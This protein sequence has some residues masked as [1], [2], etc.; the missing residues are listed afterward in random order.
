MPAPPPSSRTSKPIPEDAPLDTSTLVS[1]RRLRVSEQ[2]SRLL[3]TGFP[4]LRAESLDTTIC[5]VIQF[6]ENEVVVIGKQRG[7]TRV[8]FW[9]KAGGKERTYYLV[10]VGPDHAEEER[11]LDQY[12]KLRSAIEALY[13]NSDLV[14]TPEKNRLVVSGTAKNSQE[15]IAIITMIRRMRSIPVVDKLRV[16]ER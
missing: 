14:L 11:T 12:A 2:E 10:A 6:N 3:R 16:L 7:V 1:D 4:V 9:T 8:E 15:A 5:D 13:P